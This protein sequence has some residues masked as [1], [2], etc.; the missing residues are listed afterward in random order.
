M[1][2]AMKSRLA[3]CPVD[4]VPLLL[5]AYG[6]VVMVGCD[7]CD[8]ALAYHGP[9]LEWEPARGDRAGGVRCPS[10]VTCFADAV[11]A[12]HFQPG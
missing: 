6:G 10:R 5:V 4:G 12:F 7:L 9:R 2:E 3:R 1:S 11:L 8:R